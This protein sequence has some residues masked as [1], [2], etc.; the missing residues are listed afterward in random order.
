MHAAVEV[1]ANADIVANRFADGGHIVDGLRDLGMGV[2]VLH[3]F[4]A[5]HLHGRE[6]ACHG[7]LGLGGGI[8]RAVATN[9]GIDANLVAHRAAKQFIDGHAQSLALDIP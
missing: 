9:P 1:H 4:R 7:S 2:D 5:I 3:L 8:G 6:A